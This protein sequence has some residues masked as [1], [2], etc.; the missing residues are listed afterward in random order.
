MGA[1]SRL[2]LDFESVVRVAHDLNKVSPDVH[3]VFIGEGEQ[4]TFLQ[5]H[6]EQNANIHVMGWCNKPV[7]D[8]ILASSS[9]GLAPYSLTLAPTLPNKPFEYMAAGLPLLSS[10]EG[11]LKI[12]IEQEKIGLHY[13]AYHPDSLKGAI[14]WFLAHPEETKVMGQRAKALFIERFNTDSVYSTYVEHLNH[15]SMSRK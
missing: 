9:I 7:V 10:L 8:R 12:I 1:L 2:N 6:A 13:N 5:K 14:R 15:I 3:F 11:E 4:K